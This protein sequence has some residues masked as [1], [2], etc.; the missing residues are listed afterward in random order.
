MDTYKNRPISL[1]EIGKLKLPDIN[2]KYDTTLEVPCFAAH[3]IAKIAMASFNQDNVKHVPIFHT[4]LNDGSEK[5]LVAHYGSKSGEHILVEISHSYIDPHF[6]WFWLWWPDV[7][8]QIKYPIDELFQHDLIKEAIKT[9]EKFGEIYVAPCKIRIRTVETN[10]ET[11]LF[12]TD[13][14][15]KLV[16]S[17]KESPW[18]KFWY[19]FKEKEYE[20]AASYVGEVREL[21]KGKDNQSIFLGAVQ[22]LCYLLGQQN[23]KAVDQFLKMGID[24]HT[25]RFDRYCDACFFFA[26]EAAKEM[27]DLNRSS[28]AMKRIAQE[29]P[30]LTPDLRKEVSNILFSYAASVYIGVVVLCRRVLELVLT[31]ILTETY[32]TSIDT[33]VKRCHKAGVL[34]GSVRRGLFAILMV[35]KWK[36]FLTLSE[37]KIASHIKDF[38]NRIHDKGGVENVVDAKYAVQACIHVLRRFQSRRPHP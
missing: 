3:D 6:L 28:A 23:A 8:R 25:A 12:P 31:Q 27:G 4:T 1:I 33:L 20:L 11:F 14:L 24:F 21:S 29:I 5:D 9:G 32:E 15:Q 13:L 16:T 10:P 19:S 35:A 26:I 18:V 7:K 22:A 37:F 38:G 34:K 17:I 36:E 30:G 2:F